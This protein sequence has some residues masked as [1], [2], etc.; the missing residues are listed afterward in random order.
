MR[1]MKRTLVLTVLGFV[2][3]G[4]L[5]TASITGAVTPAGG[6]VYLSLS[7]TLIDL[8]NQLT[9]IL[10]TIADFLH[11]LNRVL[12]ELTRLFGGEAEEAIAHDRLQWTRSR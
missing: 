10:D 9:S 8:L 2:V 12:K 1:A 4:V 11:Q 7:E 5:G 3:L 6:L